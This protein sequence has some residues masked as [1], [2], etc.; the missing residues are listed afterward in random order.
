MFDWIWG[1]ISSAISSVKKW[2]EERLGPIWRAISDAINTAKSYAEGLVNSVRSWVNGIVDSLKSWVNGII[3]TLKNW[4]RD[5]IDGIKSWV[6]GIISDVR[7]SLEGL[8]SGVRSFAENLFR[9]LQ[10]S[11]QLF[12]VK[13]NDFI[14]YAT[15][16]FDELPGKVWEWIIEP[17]TSWIAQLI[18]D[19][20]AYV[21]EQMKNLEIYLFENMID[22]MKTTMYENFKQICIQNDLPYPSREEFE[23]ELENTKETLKRALEVG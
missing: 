4:V 3:N 12:Q 10:M 1:A 6:T 16:F 2:I 7:K 11:F 23:A 15:R 5:A 20:M 9:G 13:V 21:S 19:F 14:N 18:D 17:L 8:I 22:F